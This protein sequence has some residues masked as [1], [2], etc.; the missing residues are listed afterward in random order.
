MVPCD[1]M[2]AEG[3]AGSAQASKTIK[4]DKTN[5][6]IDMQMVIWISTDE[7]LKI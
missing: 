7:I 6:T 1:E 3:D 2:K 5:N 4:T